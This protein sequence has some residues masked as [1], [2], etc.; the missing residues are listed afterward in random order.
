MA[1]GV[2][3]GMVSVFSMM[4]LGLG[5][6]ITA[7]PP[8]ERDA[9]YL[10]CAPADALIYIEW[11]SRG[12]GEP[13]A[14]GFDGLVA[15]PEFA[16]FI[17]DFKSSLL[18]MVE[19]NAPPPAQDAIA[20]ALDL[21][22][23]SGCLYVN[24][25]P[26]DGAT[27]PVSPEDWLKAAQ[28][29]SVTLI[30]DGGDKADETE[31][32]LLALL[33]SIPG[34]PGG[35]GEMLDHYT[36]P[37]PVPELEIVVH[38]EGNHFIVAFGGG[39]L[40]RAQAGLKGEI[41][42]LGKS[43]AF[44]ETSKMVAMERVGTVSWFNLARIR[45][46]G[47]QFAGPWGDIAGVMMTQLGVDQLNRCLSVSGVIDGQ[48]ATRTYLE[49][50]SGQKGLLTLISGRGL[51]AD[52][53]K[54]FPKDCDFL[55]SFTLDVP[56]VRTTLKAL[57]KDVEPALADN[58]DAIELQLA[59]E[60][61]FSIED[62]LLQAF[63][64]QVTL[65]DSPAA[66]GLLFTSLT[67]TVEVKDAD[68]A[69]KVYGQLMEMLK[70]SLPGDRS[71]EFARRGVFLEEREFMDHTLYFVNTIGDDVPFAP[72]FC[73]TDEQMLVSLHPQAIKAH[74][75]FLAEGGPSYDER[76][77]KDDLPE[78]TVISYGTFSAEKLVETIYAFVPYFGQMGLSEAQ[79]NG[80]ELDVFSVPSAKAILPYLKE[81]RGWVVRTENGLLLESRSSV[82]TSLF[83][84][85]PVNW[86]LMMPRAVRIGGGA[87]PA[88]AGF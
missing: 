43:D 8:G 29:L 37:L 80:F 47:L 1:V 45:E 31:Q 76:F 50:G 83:S 68:K 65:F 70:A 16:T 72:T 59:D 10:Q 61:G 46:E 53:L 19:K 52:D 64:Q 15:D 84:G 18:A 86:L 4:L 42:G 23:R 87:V 30:L 14:E 26:P 11:A 9:A 27:Q 40:E 17:S 71:T 38:R 58:F 36:I 74:L 34:G 12:K 78:G 49:T 81:S 66:G 28:E 32:H 79:K 6:S 20:A 48:I 33:S 54:R 39:T 22:N 13:G 82:P 41:E 60:L 2:S 77:P 85:L 56:L 57:L 3:F 35:G 62:D 75:R 67:A 51:T 88:P 25:T 69:E 73:L 7:L 5:S 44:R 21:I 24:Y 63:G 55:T